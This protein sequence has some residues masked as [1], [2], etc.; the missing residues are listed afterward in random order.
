MLLPRPLDWLFDGAE[1]G[2]AYAEAV[3]RL[4]AAAP[5][6]G[7][8]Q[9]LQRA[10]RE[11][12]RSG[13]P[14]LRLWAQL[15]SLEEPSVGPAGRALGPALRALD[16]LSF[17]P[18]ALLDQAILR[19]ALGPLREVAEGGQQLW[20]AWRELERARRNWLGQQARVQARAQSLLV[21]RLRGRHQREEPVADL[22]ALSVLWLDASEAA[23]AQ[24]SR[25]DG[26]LLAQGQLVNALSAWRVELREAGD[27][28]LM[29]L[30]LPSRRELDAAHE[31]IHRQGRE[32]RQL[33]R[34]LDQLENSI[35]TPVT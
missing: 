16:Q 6:A 32:L 27:G 28:L 2:A 30:G 7:A 4:A 22:R 25:D 34:R 13:R 14:I 1:L 12:G 31:R 9:I 19:P 35:G 33:R 3:A 23:H 26:F 18:Q 5:E 15:W 29:R 17:W 21:E 10:A 11:L 8:G 24:L 20:L